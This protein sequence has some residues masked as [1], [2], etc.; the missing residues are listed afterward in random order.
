MA[1]LSTFYLSV[2]SNWNTATALLQQFFTD[3]AKNVLNTFDGQNN[4]AFIHSFYVI[5]LI[6]SRG[7][8]RYKNKRGEGE[9]RGGEGMPMGPSTEDTFRRLCD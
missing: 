3:T 6:M 4:F 5:K 1:D 7:D 2:D 9:E 8:Y